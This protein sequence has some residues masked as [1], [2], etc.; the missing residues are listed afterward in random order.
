MITCCFCLYSFYLSIHI[1]STASTNSN[2]NQLHEQ[3]HI[4]Q[5]SFSDILASG[6]FAKDKFNHLN[7]SIRGRVPYTECFNTYLKLVQFAKD[8]TIIP[9]FKSLA[10]KAKK[11]EN[12]RQSIKKIE[13]PMDISLPVLSYSVKE[14]SLGTL[15]S[16]NAPFSID[17]KTN[18]NTKQVIKLTGK[19]GV[20]ILATLRSLNL[21]KIMNHPSN[22]NNTNNNTTTSMDINN[23][24]DYILLILTEE[25][26]NELLNC[27][28]DIV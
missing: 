12:R 10:L 27:K 14:L 19:T 1:A 3:P 8:N 2:S 15:Q 13:N 25:L 5:L 6:P 9:Y 16:N 11:N 24:Q 28:T 7:E 20:C 26:E 18:T 17:N 4:Q 22:T 23:K 21:I